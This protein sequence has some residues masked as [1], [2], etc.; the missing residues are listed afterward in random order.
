MHSHEHSRSGVVL[1]YDLVN[2]AGARFPEFDA[3]LAG[4]TFKEI[5]HLLI[6]G[7]RPLLYV[8]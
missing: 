8:L 7:N 6:G 2:D 3:I 5:E 1:E 4:G